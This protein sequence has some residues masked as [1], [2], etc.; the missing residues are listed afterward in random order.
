MAEYVKQT[1]E[2]GVSPVNA[3]RLNH[4]EEGIANAGGSGGGGGVVVTLAINLETEQVSAEAGSF[5]KIQDALLNLK[6]VTLY[7]CEY[8]NNELCGIYQCPIGYWELDCMVR[9]AYG[10]ASTVVTLN[11]DDTIEK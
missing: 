5:A 9:F 3:E 10:F 4:M 6:P 7:V 11:P 2:D 1:W 8:Y